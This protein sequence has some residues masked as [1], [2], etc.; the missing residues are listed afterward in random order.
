[1]VKICSRDGGGANGF[2]CVRVDL[3][4]R[5]IF[6]QGVLVGKANEKHFC[7]FVC[8]GVFLYFPDNLKWRSETA[9]G[10]L[11]G[12]RCVCVYFYICV[13]VSVLASTN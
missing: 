13:C 8:L 11:Y 12:L 6:D 10:E 5:Y 3:D 7:V 2:V 9:H 4:L 1:M